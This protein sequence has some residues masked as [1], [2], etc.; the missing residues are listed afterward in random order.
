M[1]SFTACVITGIVMMN[2]TSS[3]RRTSINGVMLMS[4][5]GAASAPPSPTLIA[6]AF[7][8]R[9]RRSTRQ[10]AVGLGDEPDLLDAAALRQHDHATDVLVRRGTVAA[11]VDFRLRIHDR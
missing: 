7:D 8:S 5:I 2:M 6:I 4:I 9:V 1:S 3:T 10:A 11:D